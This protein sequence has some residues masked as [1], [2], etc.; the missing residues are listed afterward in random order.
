MVPFLIFALVA[1]VA[2][3]PGPHAGRRHSP[4]AGPHTHRPQTSRLLRQAFSHPAPKHRQSDPAARHPIANQQPGFDINEMLRQVNRVRARAGVRPLRL[5]A[6]LMQA[7]RRHSQDQAHLHRMTHTGS[8]GSDPAARTRQAGYRGG[9]TAENVA[10]SQRTVAQVMDAWIR[11]PIHYRNLV[12]PQLRD[13]GAAV[14]DNYWT[15][16]FG[17]GE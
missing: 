4:K 16:D 9:G 17:A 2:A 11:S 8:N 10:S 5:N 7:A 6:S 13:F 1:T 12:N 15:Q 3:I 14:V